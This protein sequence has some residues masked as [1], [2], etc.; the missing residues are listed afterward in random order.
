[1]DSTDR[2][3]FFTAT[4]CG[5]CNAIL[6]R[7]LAKLPTIDGI[8]I[9]LLGVAPGDEDYIREWAGARKIE[10]DWVHERR[11]TLNVDAGALDKFSLRLDDPLEQRPV[12]LRRRGDALLLFIQLP[13]FDTV[14]KWR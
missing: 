11:V 3:L 14:D 9:Y 12:V 10:P 1:M 2:V 6:D 4:N 5:A 13:G 7:L 8:D